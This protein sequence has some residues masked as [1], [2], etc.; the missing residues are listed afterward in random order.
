MIGYLALL[1]FAAGTAAAQTSDEEAPVNIFIPIPILFY[2]PETKFAFGAA[3]SYIYRP[4]GGTL[5]DRPSSMSATAIMTT[6]SQAMAAFSINHYWDHERNNASASVLYRKFPDVFFGIGNNTATEGED[7]TDEGPLVSFDYLR[8]IYRRLRAGGGFLYGGSSITESKSGGLL[9]ADHI[10]GSQGGQI[11]GAGLQINLDT[12]D[13]VGYPTRGGLFDVNW[14][15]YGT[16]LG[17]DFKMNSVLVD[18]RRFFPLGKRQVIAVRAYGVSTGGNVPFQLMPTLGGQSLMRGYYAG[19]FRDH[20]A[21]LAQAELRFKIWK[22]LGGA[23][24]ASLGQVAAS[25]EQI[26]ADR[27]HSAYGF[28]LRTLLIRQEGLNLRF[29]WGYGEDQSGF[30]FGLGESF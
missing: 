1:C 8:R 18:L 17:A 11:A 26:A 14:K 21:V 22:R 3:C 15:V 27:T 12:R 23:V 5:Q 2:T 24:F 6:R 28:G 30:Y 9:D 29:D 19:R 25:I 10:S 16:V 7:F 4:A 13:N 20:K